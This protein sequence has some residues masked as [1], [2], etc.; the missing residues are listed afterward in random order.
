M[1][2]ALFISVIHI[3]GT[4][5]IG[6]FVTAML[7]QYTGV[8]KVLAADT[9]TERPLVLPHLRNILHES[10]T[11]QVDSAHCLRLLGLERQKSRVSEVD[12]LLLS[13]SK[14]YKAAGEIFR[15]CGQAGTVA[16][17]QTER[18]GKSPEQAGSIDAGNLLFPG[19]SPGGLAE[20]T[21]TQHVEISLINESI[22]QWVSAR[23]T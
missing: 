2:A 3:T 9:A 13:A 18:E 16:S 19:T 6:V 12:Q 23:K 15:C 22:Y 10:D 20:R 17:Q 21:C 11:S 8:L 7:P 5:D 14:W 1:H 4:D